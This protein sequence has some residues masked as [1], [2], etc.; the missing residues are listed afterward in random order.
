V[1]FVVASSFLRAYI[2]KLI[3]SEFKPADMAARREH[4]AKVAAAVH[5]QPWKPKDNVK[6]AVDPE[7]E[8]EIEASGVSAEDDAH[9]KKV[10]AALPSHQALAGHSLNVLDFEKD[11]DRNFHIDFVYSAANLRAVAYEIPTVSRLQS[12]LIAG[13]I[14]PAIVTTTAVVA[15]LVCLELIK[16]ALGK[17]KLEDYRNCFCNLAIPVFNMAEV[18]KV[19]LCVILVVST[20]TKIQGRC[21]DQVS[22]PRQDI[23]HVGSRGNQGGQSDRG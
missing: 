17:N 9:M 12:K 6:I 15:G 8:K 1:D 4:I 22:V 11:D 19:F 18:E 13:K 5:V 23:H 14:I 3:P 21:P 16:L 10:L 20:R 2:L 7:K